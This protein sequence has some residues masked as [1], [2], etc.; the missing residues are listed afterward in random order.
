MKALSWR[1]IQGLTA[2]IKNE[3]TALNFFET[4]SAVNIRVNE[5]VIVLIVFSFFSCVVGI[6][7]KKHFTNNTLLS[8]D[9]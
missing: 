7:M 6:Y 1:D 3:G 4:V 9:C 5:Y 2:S 8:Y